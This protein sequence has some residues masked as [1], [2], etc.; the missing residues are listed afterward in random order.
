M[1]DSHSENDVS[2]FAAWA[3]TRVE[4]PDVFLHLLAGAHPGLAPDSFG[5]V[6]LLRDHV[7]GVERPERIAGFPLDDH[8]VQ[9][10]IQLECAHVL[11]SRK[12]ETEGTRWRGSA[13]SDLCHSPPWCALRRSRQPDS[14]ANIPP[15]APGHTPRGNLRSGRT[16]GCLMIPG[17]LA[18]RGGRPKMY[19]R[20][21][22]D[23]L[24]DPRTPSLIFHRLV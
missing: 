12:G 2:P 24:D 16:S 20:W 15:A 8:R 19:S 4:L 7:L 23:V 6:V 17:R 10:V 18:R 14:A 13:P 9:L 11:L 3:R 1:L 21:I 5:L 22:R